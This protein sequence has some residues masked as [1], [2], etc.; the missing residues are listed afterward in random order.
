[1][2]KILQRMESFARPLLNT[3]NIA[4][5]FHYSPTV[6]QLNLPMQWRKNFYLIFKE[7]INNV[8][9]Y[10]DAVNMQVSL[11]QH[12]QKIELKVTDDGRGFD[13][14]TM[15]QMAAKSLSGNGLVNMKRRAAEMKGQCTIESRIGQGTT[16]CL[17][18]PIP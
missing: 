14:N 5:S 10:S 9:K 12:G 8:I 6:K 1:M 7:A 13:V 11:Q 3:K 17:Q 16:I 15:K 18:F 4:C 2:E